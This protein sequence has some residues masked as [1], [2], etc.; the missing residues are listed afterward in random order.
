MF[1]SRDRLGLGST[2]VVD[3]LAALLGQ[4]GE[5]LAALGAA[6]SVEG[7][8]AGL[9]GLVVVAA[10]GPVTG[11]LGAALSECFADSGLVGGGG[12]VIKVAVCAQGSTK[13]A[14]RLV[15]VVGY[16][17][18]GGQPFGDELVEVSGGPTVSGGFGE[19][20]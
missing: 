5:D 6:G 11:T 13:E 14:D 18:P 1:G 7:G 19:Q 10:F 9:A 2:G 17:V 8:A 12:A 16:A 20:S 15:G 3:P 4:V